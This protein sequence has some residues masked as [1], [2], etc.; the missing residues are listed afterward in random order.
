MY[1][2]TSWGLLCLFPLVV[3]VFAFIL[4]M[5]L[6][7]SSASAHHPLVVNKSYKFKLKHPSD[8]LCSLTCRWDRQIKDSLASSRLCFELHHLSDRTFHVLSVR[9][10]MHML[11]PSK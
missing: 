8:L 1:V 6:H 7:R 9:H 5:S 11:I 2:K 4:E 3:L 10:M